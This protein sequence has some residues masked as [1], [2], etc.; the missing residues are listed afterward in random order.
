MR[1]S[2]SPR[3]VRS[4]FLRVVSPLLPLFDCL[5]LCMCLRSFVPCASRP[6]PSAMLR[7]S[8]PLPHSCSLGFRP[9]RVETAATHTLTLTNTFTFAQTQTHTHTNIHRRVAATTSLVAAARRDALAFKCIPLLRSV[10]LC[11]HLPGAME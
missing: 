7:L 5:C 8:A 2:R 9:G 1:G 10:G 3:S 11:C 6:V 4:L